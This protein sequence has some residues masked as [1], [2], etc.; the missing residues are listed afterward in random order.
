[1]RRGASLVWTV[2]PERWPSGLR[3]TLGKRVYVKAYRGFE[4]HSLRQFPKSS[5]PQCPSTP[6]LSGFCTVVSHS[7]PPSDPPDHADRLVVYGLSNERN[8]VAGP[9]VRVITGAGR[10]SAT[11]KHHAYQLSL[12]TL[13][14][15]SPHS[16]FLIVSDETSAALARSSRFQSRKQRAARACY[17]F[18]EIHPDHISH[19]TVI[20]SAHI[21]T[22]Q[23]GGLPSQHRRRLRIL[24]VTGFDHDRQTIIAVF[25]KLA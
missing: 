20:L 10:K 8:R 17:R 6:Y 21:S 4:S 18:P 25:E 3:R 5:S 22:R 14:R 13:G 16:K 7:R 24:S 23:R 19:V 1:L 2:P 9:G 11:A 15:Q 12:G